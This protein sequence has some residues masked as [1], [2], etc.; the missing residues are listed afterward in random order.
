[1]HS[2]SHTRVSGAALCV[3]NQME[4]NY[5]SVPGGGGGVTECG[6]THAVGHACSLRKFGPSC[7]YPCELGAQRYEV[8]K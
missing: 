3:I 5:T 6:A 7:T 4:A 1:M 8:K 2:G